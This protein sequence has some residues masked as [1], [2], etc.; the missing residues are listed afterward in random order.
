MQA[1]APARGY[2]LKEMH[3]YWD[4][5]AAF[6]GTND[7]YG[8][9]IIR[10]WLDK[11]QPLSLIEIGCGNG[12]LF[13]AYRDVPHVVA[14]DWSEQMIHRANQ[15]KGLHGMTHIQIHRHDICQSAPRG[16]Y[17]VAVTRTVLM[18]IPEAH[19]EKAIR[20]IAAVADTII[21]LEYYESVQIRELSPH[22]WLH[23]YIPLFKRQKCRLIEAYQRPDQPQILFVFRRKT[24]RHH[25]M[26]DGKLVPV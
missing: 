13:P 14:V 19:V 4:A 20:H 9:N 6:Y 12:E 16:H 3:R 21:A 15:R 18:H 22:C 25:R 8:R 24:A 2:S 10:A 11:L 26:P 5:R 1:R 7:V 23:D 17:D